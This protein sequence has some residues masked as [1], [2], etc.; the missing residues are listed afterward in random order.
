MRRL[1]QNG[2]SREKLTLDLDEIAR[3]GAR[4]ML[5]EALEAEVQDYLQAARGER[6]EDGRALVVRNGHARER[7]SP[8]ISRSLARAGPGRARGATHVLHVHQCATGAARLPSPGLR[9]VP[10]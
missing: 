7:R 1:H 4:R 5:A 8:C 6:G 9:G 2:V 3:A 10:T